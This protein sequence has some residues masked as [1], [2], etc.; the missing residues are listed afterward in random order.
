MPDFDGSYKLMF[1]NPEFVR[2]T[3]LSVLRNKNK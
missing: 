3:L 2:D 1:R